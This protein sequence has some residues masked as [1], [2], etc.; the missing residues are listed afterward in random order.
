MSWA[1]LKVP[2]IK[3]KIWWNNYLVYYILQIPLKKTLSALRLTYDL[4]NSAADILT[5]VNWKG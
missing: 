3:I 2:L 5:T 1:S 4:V